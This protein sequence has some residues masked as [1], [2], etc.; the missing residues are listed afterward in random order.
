M[1]VKKV[2]IENFKNFNELNVELDNFNILIGANACGKSNFI[3][4]FRFIKDIENEGLENAISMQGGVEYLRNINLGA[5]KKLRFKIVLKA[6]KETVSPIRQNFLSEIYEIIYEFVLEFQKTRQSYRILKDEMIRKFELFK[7]EKKDRKKI[8]KENL[9]KG[10]LIVSKTKGNIAYKFIPPN[11]FTASLK[12]LFYYPYRHRSVIGLKSKELLIETPFIYDFFYR[13]NLFDAAIYDFDPKLPKKSTPIK[14]KIALEEDGSN[15][16]LILN[17]IIRNK[18]RE[19]KFSNLIKDF[20]PFIEKVDIDKLVDKSLIFKLREKYFQKKYLPASLIS[21]GTIHITA[22]IVALYFEEYFNG[23]RLTIIEEPE[24]NIHPHLISKVVDMM[25]NASKSKQIL[26]TTHNPEVVRHA[27]LENL[28]F[29]YRDKDGFSSISRPIEK[30]EVKKFLE[31]EIGIE[32]LY[33]QD[34]LG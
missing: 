12:D 30:K 21:D 11:G 32:E 27:E 18:D 13:K 2:E 10:E 14:G 33:I 22:L 20:L 6:E 7:I 29:M 31:N 19:R 26:V 28:L 15:L 8:R 5:S 16:A 3:Q 1:I 4:I 34:L 24:R 17:N 9:G 25:K 23:G